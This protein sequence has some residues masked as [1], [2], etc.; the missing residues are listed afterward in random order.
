LSVYGLES[1]IVQSVRIDVNLRHSIEVLLESLIS[2][3][4]STAKTETDKLQIETKTQ[5]QIYI[6]EQRA[7]VKSPEYIYD[8]DEY[9]AEDDNCN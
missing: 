2:K 8:S 1:T 4:Y 3:I 7:K 6:I 9:L 5:R